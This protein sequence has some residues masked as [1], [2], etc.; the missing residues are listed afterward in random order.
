MSSLPLARHAAGTV[1]APA[2][3][4]ARVVRLPKLRETFGELPP[5]VVR[6][7]EEAGADWCEELAVQARTAKSLQDLGL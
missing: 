5:S 6:Q 7:I 1:G 3:K 4:V 2:A